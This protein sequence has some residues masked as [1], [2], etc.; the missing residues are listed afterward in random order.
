MNYDSISTIAHEQPEVVE[1][2]QEALNKVLARSAT[3]AGFRTR[4]LADP[5]E[6]LAE[7]LGREVP[8]TFDIA[9]VEN[10][11]GVT[12]VLPDFVD[13]D[14]ELSEDDLEAVAGG[15]PIIL[16]GAAALYAGYQVGRLIEEIA[17]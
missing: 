17:D 13:P 14:A 8:A 5:R 7:A 1:A 2:G 4:L 12:V 16:V 11:A 9:F 3:D 15:L 6:A 10:T